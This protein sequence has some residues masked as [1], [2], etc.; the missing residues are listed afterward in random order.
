MLHAG[1]S[2]ERHNFGTTSMCRVPMRLRQGQSRVSPDVQTGCICCASGDGRFGGP[3]WCVPSALFACSYCKFGL[4]DV[5]LSNI[6][7]STCKHDAASW[8][9][10]QTSFMMQVEHAARGRRRGRGGEPG[11]VGAFGRAGAG[12]FGACRYTPWPRYCFLPRAG[13]MRPLCGSTCVCK[14]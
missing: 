5:V 1:H 3:I 13:M 2:E 14:H 11:D 12:A 8:S 9:H 4:T 6:F 10:V 7:D